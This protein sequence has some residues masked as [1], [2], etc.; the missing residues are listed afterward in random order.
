LNNSEP[1]KHPIQY[2]CR[3][4]NRF[5]CPY[6]RTNIKE[7]DVVGTTNSHFDVED[8]FRLQK[9]A[10]IVE[11]ALARARKSDSEIQI[12]DKQDLLHALTDRDTFTK[13]LEQGADTFKSTEYLRENSAG[14]DNDC[15]VDYFMRIKDKICLEELRFY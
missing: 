6:E 1:E 3:V 15:I 8:L 7:A 13:I 4:V 14:Q 5:Q 2:P 12:K 9:M 11:I 10:F